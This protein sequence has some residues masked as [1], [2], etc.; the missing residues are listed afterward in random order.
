MR[1]PA[2]A[3]SPC[4]DSSSSWASAFDNDAGWRLDYQFATPELALTF[5]HAFGHRVE[6]PVFLHFLDVVAVTARVHVHAHH[7]DFVPL[8]GAHISFDPASRIHVFAEPGQSDARAFHRTVG[9]DAK[10]LRRLAPMPPR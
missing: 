7:G 6:E 8:R 4:W 2:A 3:S 1:S 5:T 10:G 9:Q